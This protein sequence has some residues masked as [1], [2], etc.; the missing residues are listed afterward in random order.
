MRRTVRGAGALVAMGA[1][2][3]GLGACSDGDDDEAATGSGGESSDLTADDGGADAAAFCEAAVEVDVVSRGLESGEAT[4]EDMEAA[5]QAALDASPSPLTDQVTTLV[6]EAEAMMAAAETADPEGPP[7]LPSD[8]Y[9]AAAAEVGGFLA[10]DCGFE[11][12]DVETQ[13]YAFAGI[14]AEV[15]AGTTVINVANNATEIHEL[16]LMKIADGETRPVEELMA[17]PEEEVGQLVTEVS[18]VIA[19]P[20]GANFATAELDPGRYVGICFVP[21]GATPEA[22]ASGAPLDDSDAH[23]MHGM[24][25]EFTVT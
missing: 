9:G 24:V 14:P 15:P 1:L 10:S 18:F 25:A 3:I 22:L 20:G 13:N 8:A 23:A 21:V 12:L 4:P 7:P 5:L 19:M 11:T 17:L 2:V 16:A 6:D